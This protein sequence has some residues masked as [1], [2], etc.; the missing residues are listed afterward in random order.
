MTVPQH[1]EPVAGLCSPMGS[2]TSENESEFPS[3]HVQFCG[4]KLGVARTLDLTRRV[5]EKEG[6][7][8]AE[9]NAST[10]FHSDCSLNLSRGKRGYLG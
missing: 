1:Y 4:L 9:S 2:E 10:C 3:G 8:D 6:C 7:R 5:D